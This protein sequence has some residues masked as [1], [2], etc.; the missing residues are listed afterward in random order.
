MFGYNV[1]IY[2]YYLFYLYFCTYRKLSFLSLSYSLPLTYKRFIVHIQ[3]RMSIYVILH[4][5]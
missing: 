2:M 5:L 3:Q 4:M 1:Y